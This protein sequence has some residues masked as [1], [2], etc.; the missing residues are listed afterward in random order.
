MPGPPLGEMQANAQQPPA[1][2]P[3]PKQGKASLAV[4]PF[5]A[6]PDIHR[7]Y[8]AD[9]DLLYDSLV[10][11]FVKTNKFDVLER[12]RIDSVIEENHFAT[13]SLGDPANLASFGKLTGAQYLVVGTVRDLGV[14]THRE[15]IP[16]TSEIKCTETARLRL[17]VRV[18]QAR[19]GRIVSAESVGDPSGSGPRTVSCSRSRQAVLDEAMGRTAAGLVADIVDRIYPLTVV[20]VA[21]DDLT[22]NR[23]EG[24]AFQVGATLACVM[25][26]EQI[27][28]PGTGETLGSAE[29]PVGN[30]T[31]T[32]IA[33]KMSKARAEVAGSVPV[34]A[35]C[36]VTAAAPKPAA[37]PAAPRANVRW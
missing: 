32:R 17:E 31:V 16:Y 26:G 24:G 36:R 20:H 14:S 18:V 28:D 10:R 13:S 6:N 22:L 27:V 12:T 5:Q 33:E 37:R 23:G 35:V 7:S 34:G 3:A 8:T 29:S 19:T 9:L 21:G 4:V 25:E 30:I 2:G 1:A 11:L 15:A